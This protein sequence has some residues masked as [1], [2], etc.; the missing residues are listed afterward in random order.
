MRSYGQRFV[1]AR[2]DFAVRSTPRVNQASIDALQLPLPSDPRLVRVTDALLR[3]PTDNRDL[4]HWAGIAGASIRTLVRLF[5]RETGMTFRQWR[6]QARLLAA[7]ERLGAG[8][9]VTRVAR[10]VGCGGPAGA[11]STPGTR[12]GAR[13]GPSPRACSGWA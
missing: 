5:P 2:D 11:R 7:L 6:R 9:P 12:R 4:E 3:D 1:P 10:D 8:L 13:G